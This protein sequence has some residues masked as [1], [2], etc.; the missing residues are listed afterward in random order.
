M[1]R[2]LLVCLVCV[3]LTFPAAGEAVEITASH[4][5]EPLSALEMKTA[6][7][8]VKARFTSDPNLPDKKAASM[9]TVKWVIAAY[10]NETLHVLPD[11]TEI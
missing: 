1:K 11:D 8:I 6:F 3:A 2:G 5:L 9:A 10:D 4:P 7:E